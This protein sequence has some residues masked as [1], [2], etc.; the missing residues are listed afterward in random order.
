MSVVTATIY[1]AEEPLPAG[2]ELI[3][4]VVCKEVG[5]IPYANARFLDGDIATQTFPFSDA[6]ELA[7]G[8]VIKIELRYEGEADV[9]VFEGLVTRQSLEVSARGAVLAVECKDAGVKLT[10][11]RTRA[12]F[13]GLSDDKV[14]AK[15]VVDAGLASPTV[16]ATTPVHAEL[17]QYAATDWDF[18][19]MRARAQG[20][21]V[22][23]DDGVL[24]ASA[25]E[26][27]GKTTHTLE[28]GIDEIYDFDVEL[29]A[30]GQHPAVS[31]L[32]WD[33]KAQALTSPAA[34]KELSLKQGKVKPAA[35]GTALG[36]PELALVNAL[37]VQPEELQ[38]WADGR[39]ARRRLA[40]I[41]GRV[42][43]KGDAALKPLDVLELKSVGA[44]F[45]GETLITGVR[46]QVDENGWR[47]DVQFGLSP[48]LFAHAPELAAPPAAGLVPPIHGLQVGVVTA[49]EADPDKELRV[50]VLLP[51]LG[52]LETPVWARLAA[53]EAGKG[54]GF[55]FRPEVGDEVVVGFF[56]SDP[57][58]AVILGAM[59]GSSNT[60]PPEFEATLESNAMKGIVTR[61]GAMIA[62]DDEK[63]VVSIVT[64]KKISV[65]LDDDQE[66]LTLADVHGNTITMD[67][68][69]IVIKSAKDLTIDGSGGDVKILGKAVDV[70]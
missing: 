36:V 44:R 56:N 33:L 29:D 20:L 6:P 9:T 1:S 11:T 8:A 43:T 2:F 5:K 42:A 21:L 14:I 63:S 58:Q 13:S 49:F 66:S 45:A 17:V 38:A 15:I 62:V 59:F 55:F 39:L 10:Q 19:L 70:A 54:R 69:G 31:S 26:I 30:A 24:S 57:R 65:V 25:I 34:G 12:V 48:E 35:A 18:I 67:K 68:G 16:P 51:A 3:S 4:L 28:Y 22:V 32:G 37:A 52:E 23:L 64:A 41:R 50:R 7:P 46:H 60:P 27:K 40:M 53:P 47:T 61:S